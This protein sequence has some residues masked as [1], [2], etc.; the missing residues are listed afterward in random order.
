MGQAPVIHLMPELFEKIMNNEFEPKEIVTHK[1]S[2]EEASQ[3]Y[4]L[5]NYHEDGC[6]KVVLK[7]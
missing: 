1:M 6:I 2:L 3:G 4:K 7:P 5:F